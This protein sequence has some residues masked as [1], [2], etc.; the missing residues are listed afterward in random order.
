MMTTSGLER[1]GKALEADIEPGGRST[2]SKGAYA[3]GTLSGLLFALAGFFLTPVLSTFSDMAFKPVTEWNTDITPGGMIVGAPMIFL[4]SSLGFAALRRSGNI[5]C[6]FHL[7]TATGLV[8]AGL[9]VS[10]GT[11]SVR[12][13]RRL[14]MPHRPGQGMR[15]ARDPRD[16]YPRG[17]HAGYSYLQPPSTRRRRVRPQPGSEAGLGPRNA[18]GVIV[19]AQHA[20]IDESAPR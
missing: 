15:H 17:G 3:L 19:E 20:M 9:G 10:V 1:M 14:L 6:G 5:A 7:T 4:G 2:P 13:D 8:G 12:R 11:A 16:D 18:A